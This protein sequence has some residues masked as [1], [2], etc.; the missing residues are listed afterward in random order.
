MKNFCLTGIGVLMIASVVPAHAQDA[1]DWSFSVGAGALVTPTYQGDDAYQVLVV[2][3]IRVTYKNRF[4]VSV[5]EGARYNAVKTER[6]RAGPIAKIDFGRDDDGSSP[7]RVDGG[8]ADDL[9]G[10]DTIDAAIELGGFVTYHANPIE[11][12]AELRQAVGGHEGMVGNL[13][14]DYKGKAQLM[15]QALI[16]SLGPEVRFADSNYHDAYFGVNATESSASGLAQYDADAGILSYDFGG[17]VIVPV[18]DQLSTVLFANYSY[19]GDEAAESSLVE[20][21]GSA[22]QGTAGVSVNY[23]F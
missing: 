5:R 7:F 21:R 23:T 1:Q 14:L 19:L 3:D 20:E 8:D 11:V 22:H 10:L 12:R 13:S 18:T 4:F 16:Y 2:P 15:K 6:W 9:R 17:S